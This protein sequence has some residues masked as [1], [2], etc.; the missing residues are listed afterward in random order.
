MISKTTIRD[1]KDL[2]PLIIKKISTFDYLVP[3]TVIRNS[4]KDLYLVR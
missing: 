3:G 2:I 4:T 1:A